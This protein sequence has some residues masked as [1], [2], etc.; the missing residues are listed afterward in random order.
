MAKFCGD[1][2]VERYD[3][4]IVSKPGDL[5]SPGAL[6]TEVTREM[7]HGFIMDKFE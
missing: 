5:S 3:A 1:G 2:S 6:S 7:Y 4:E